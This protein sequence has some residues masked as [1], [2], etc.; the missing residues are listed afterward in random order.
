MHNKKLLVVVVTYNSHK[1]IEWALAPLLDIELFQIRI[2]DSGSSDVGYLKRLEAYEN[3]EVHYESNL[4]F[5]KGNNRALYDID[6]F[7][8]VLFLNPDARIELD[9][10]NELLERAEYSENK[11]NALFSVALEKFSIDENKAV[12]AYDSLG[13]YC[14]AIG[15][16]KDLQGPISIAKG[17]LKY[18]AVCGAFMLCRSKALL[19][20]PDSRGNIGFEESFFMYKEDIE[21]SLRIGKKWGIKI[22]NDLKAYHCRGWAGGRGSN[23]YWARKRSAENDVYVASHYKLRALPYAILKYLYVVLLEKK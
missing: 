3:V 14:D 22:F 6:Q 16:W 23:P 18:E 4:G 20:F 8:Y 17:N 13:I 10:L 9:Q 2:V 15:R 12:N 19:Q 1:F 7:D 11:K 21:L 5:A